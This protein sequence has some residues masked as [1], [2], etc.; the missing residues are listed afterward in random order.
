MTMGVYYIVANHDRR[1]YVSG[2]SEHVED[3]PGYKHG[4]L[5]GVV[6]S[7]VLALL[8]D[9]LWRGPQRIEV[10]SDAED[11]ERFADIEDGYTDVSAAGRRGADGGVGT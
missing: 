4:Q 5:I 3:G 6:A 1:E 7:W 2:A 11:S 9:G 10:L 8:A